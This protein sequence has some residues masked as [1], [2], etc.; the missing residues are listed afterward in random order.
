L[1]RRLVNTIE[2]ERS[3]DIGCGSG[4]ITKALAEASGEVVAVDVNEDAIDV[5]R[6]ALGE[7]ST[8]H[9]KAVDVFNSSETVSEWR[10]S[11]DLVVLSEVLEHIP[12][13]RGA[14]ATAGQLLSDRGWLLLTV[15]GDP[16]LWNAEDERAGHVR[17][18][19]REELRRKLTDSG[20]EIDELINWGFP[21]TKWLYRLEVGMMERH[22]PA[23]NNGRSHPPRLP[24]RLLTLARP[25]IGALAH[26]EAKLSW[27]DRGVGYVVFARKA[28]TRPVN[29]LHESSIARRPRTT[30]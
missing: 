5:S 14:L 24:I 27:L 17:R 8:V 23:Q 20:F 3:L 12:D 6:R 9:L 10:E 13:D 11:F 4:L 30:G 21:L 26:L 22:R 15:P 19:T 18:Y 28:G 2:P 25:F 7:A 29:K 1:I 16:K